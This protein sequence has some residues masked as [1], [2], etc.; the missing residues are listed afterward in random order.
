M[1]TNYQNNRLL[2]ID[3]ARGLAVFFMIA[4]HTL[5]TFG[6]EEVND[7]LF[8][9]I[10]GFLGGPPAAPVFM[11]LMGFSFLYSKKS[12]FRLKLFRGFKIF[13]LGYVLNL[14]RGVLPF[15]LATYSK[16]ELIATTELRELN[17]YELFFMIDIL[18]FAGIALILM[19]IIQRFSLNKYVIL[20]IA[21]S[22]ALISPLFW[23]IK[24]NIPIFDFVLDI[25]WGDHEI[26]LIENRVAFPLLPWLTFPL[27][28]MF[29]GDIIKN[30]AKR[31]IAF[32]QVGIVGLVV[33]L[34]GLILSATNFDYHFND[35]YHSRQGAMIFMCGFVMLW[36]YIC[37]I[38]TDYVPTNYVFNL[39]YDWS[40]FVTNIYFIQWVLICWSIGLFGIQ[41]SSYATVIALIILFTVISHFLS[42]LLSKMK[43]NKK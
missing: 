37:K 41:S 36:V 28:G 13:L 17:A 15:I 3:M 8:G 39:I 14:A 7:S 5:M 38:M 12:D 30:S 40:K 25:I 32:K 2:S 26:P 19:A 16:S 29:L 43:K 1:D 34:A 42:F 10:V 11:T 31:Q 33:L 4:V 6:T 22:I 23:G 27:L 18:Q 9:E 35:Y 24:T 21:V 20:A